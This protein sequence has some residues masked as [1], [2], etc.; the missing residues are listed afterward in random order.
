MSE[1]SGVFRMTPSKDASCPI[2]SL[3][4]RARNRHCIKS[5]DNLPTSIHVFWNGIE[6]DWTELITQVPIF[7]KHNSHVARLGARTKERKDCNDRSV[8]SPFLSTDY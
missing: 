4:N 8:F 5:L 3:C 2:S 1:I 7:H 6:L